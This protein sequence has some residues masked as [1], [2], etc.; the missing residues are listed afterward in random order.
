M[1]EECYKI[2]N[3][4][5][6]LDFIVNSNVY[7]E[8]QVW[9]G[10]D[11]FGYPIMRTELEFDATIRTSRFEKDTINFSE[12]KHHYDCFNDVH[13]EKNLT[14]EQELDI[15]T[16]VVKN[17][18]R[19]YI[20]NPCVIEE[21]Y[22]KDEISEFTICNIKSYDKELVCVNPDLWNSESEYEYA[23]VYRLN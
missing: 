1:K 4:M 7:Q 15:I 23:C 21:G 12:I 13:I 18:I 10:E 22:C 16:S 19:E 2:T 3:I 8:V 20:L 9:D 11:E 17:K 6:E 5:V 14:G